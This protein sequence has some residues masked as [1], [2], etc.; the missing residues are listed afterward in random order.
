[1][2]S[3][4]G[5][6]CTRTLSPLMS[7]IFLIS[8]LEYMLRRPNVAPAMTRAPCPV[9]RDF[10]LIIGEAIMF[11]F[12][13]GRACSRHDRGSGRDRC[14]NL[15]QIAHGF[16]PSDAFFDHPI[17]VVGMSIKHRAC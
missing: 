9:T 16:S 6:A 12:L 1:M 4:V 11:C 17:E 2:V 5:V 14:E 7:S 15:F 8:R 13:R 10:R 3:S